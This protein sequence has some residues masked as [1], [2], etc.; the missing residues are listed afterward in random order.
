MGAERESSETRLALS[1]LRN[2]PQGETRHCGGGARGVGG[3]KGVSQNSGGETWGGR[4]GTER[5]KVTGAVRHSR[6]RPGHCP[7]IG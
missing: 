3:E 5:D 7:R 1:V 4:R 2:L 6:C